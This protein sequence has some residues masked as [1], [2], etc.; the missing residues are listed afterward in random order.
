M[1]T[2]N[3]LPSAE[4]LYQHW[5]E[6]L[7]L[8]KIGRIYGKSRTAVL[9]AIR[10][11]Y[12]IHACSPKVNGLAR[13]IVQEYGDYQYLVP[14]ARNIEGRFLTSKKETNLSTF[15]SIGFEEELKY[16]TN[17][18]PEEEEKPLR[19]PLFILFTHGVSYALRSSFSPSSLS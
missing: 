16:S 3:K 11:K 15:Q 8:R 12:G 9:S 17:V 2:T 1:Q 18:L 19:L 13:V 14:A 4:T 5:L 10:A 7:S 6:G